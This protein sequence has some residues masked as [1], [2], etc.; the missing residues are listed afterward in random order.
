MCPYPGGGEQ[1]PVFGQAPALGGCVGGVSGLQVIESRR[2]Q[3]SGFSCKSGTA[4][5]VE[6]NGMLRVRFWNYRGTGAAL[7]EK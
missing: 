3:P 1:V 5:L 2:A 7:N 4:V 6:E